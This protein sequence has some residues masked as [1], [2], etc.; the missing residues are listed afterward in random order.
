MTSRRYWTALGTLAQAIVLCGC[1]GDSVTAVGGDAIC[2][3][4]PDFRASVYVLPYPV[5]RS[6]RLMTANCDLGHVGTN[7]YGYDFAMA[8]GEEITAMHSGTAVVVSEQFRDDDRGQGTSNWLILDHGDGTYGTYFHMT[9]DGVVPRVGDFVR[10]GELVGYAGSSGTGDPHVHVHVKSC[11]EAAEF[12][13]SEPFQFRNAHPEPT[14]T[15]LQRGVV[16][17]ALPYD[18][19]GA[20]PVT[21]DRWGSDLLIPD[22]PAPRRPGGGPRDALPEPGARRR[23]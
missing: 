2:E 14:P 17:T 16:Y 18:A 20:G 23:P 22:T 21:L 10:Q 1:D 15:G 6:Y 9:K 3:G 11:L 13:L 4:Y 8:I 5:G 12:C 7:R 19:N